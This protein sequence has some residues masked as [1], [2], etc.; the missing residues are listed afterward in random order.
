MPHWGGIPGSEVGRA[1]K[2]SLRESKSV[3]GSLTAG[4]RGVRGTLRE[5]ESMRVA[6]TDKSAG[7]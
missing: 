5:S 7:G 3:K 4:R 6:L 1:V 2:G